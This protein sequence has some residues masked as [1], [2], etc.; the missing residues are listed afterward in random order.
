MK[1][2]RN[3]WITSLIITLILG[4]I[5][6][7]FF[8]LYFLY[9]TTNNAYVKTDIINVTSPMP[10]IVKNIN[11]QNN[12][13]INKDDLLIKLEEDSLKDNYQQ[14]K[15]KYE[16]AKINADITRQKIEALES[17]RKILE[18]AKELADDSFEVLDESLRQVSSSKTAKSLVDKAKYQELIL[19]HKK[20]KFEKQKAEIELAS[21]QEEKQM[22]EEGLKAEKTNLKSLEQTLELAKNA[23][24][25]TEIYSTQKGIISNIKTYPGDYVF[26]GKTLCSI[27]SLD[28]PK[29]IATFK[30][31]QLKDIEVGK[32]A[33]I[34]LDSYPNQKLWGKVENISPATDSNF[35]I[36][37]KLNSGSSMTKIMQTVSV[38]ISLEVEDKMQGKI[39]PG[40]SSKVS[41]KTR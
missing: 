19:Q 40:M 8:N 11:H 7:K 3:F 10:G 21:V 22:M 26:P 31:T 39:L 13:N 14:A 41:I 2:I 18:A 28:N 15:Y 12:T 24:D 1:N 32:K 25:M 4:G 16:A 38:E 17:K 30:E 33:E 34:V 37:P 6:Y 29:I 36:L 23:W 20:T 35:S 5:G 9:Q 27:V